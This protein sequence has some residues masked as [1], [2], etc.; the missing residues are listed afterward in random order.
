MSQPRRKATYDELL[1]V[2]EHKV[3]EIIAGEL[4]VSPRPAS[5]HALAASAIGSVLFDRFNRPPG[6]GAVPGGWWIL[7]EPELHL[8]DDVIVPDLA[9]WRRARMPTFPDIAAFTIPPDW[10]CEV[11]SAST[12]RVDRGPKMTIYARER[13]GHLWFVAPLAR[14]LEVHRLETQTFTRI[15]RHTGSGEIIAEP[16]ETITLELA[17][18]W[19]EA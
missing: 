12:K 5:P 14:V 18:W 9:G 19:R 6:S 8:G 7:Y 1:A 2:P 15:A 10:V 17:R 4:V 16:F 13:V 3:A 11:L